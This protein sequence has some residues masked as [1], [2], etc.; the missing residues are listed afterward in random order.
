MT[1]LGSIKTRDQTRET[2]QCRS[3]VFQMEKG[4][5][6]VVSMNSLIIVDAVLFRKIDPNY[7]RL[8]IN[9]PK[10]AFRWPCRH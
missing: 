9:L 10:K 7:S 8:S 2:L 4:D 5:P 6:V 3:R 1:S